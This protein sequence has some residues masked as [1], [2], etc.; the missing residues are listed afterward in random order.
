MEIWKLY[1]TWE[2][3]S[4]LATIPC[5][6]FLQQLNCLPGIRRNKR[7]PKQNKKWKVLNRLLEE[8][9]TGMI[10]FP[11][12]QVWVHLIRTRLHTH[13]SIDLDVKEIFGWTASC[14]IYLFKVHRFL[15]WQTLL[16]KNGNFKIGNNW[17]SV[18]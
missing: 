3:H 1:R 10:R 17:W 14:I 4:L 6:S 11:R 15:L 8:W 12:P 5:I 13:D 16:I 18:C 9:N 2:L 7:C